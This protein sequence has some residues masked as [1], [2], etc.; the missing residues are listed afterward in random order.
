M[1]ILTW[2][3][4]GSNRRTTVFPLVGWWL[5]AGAVMTGLVLLG[6]TVPAG[7]TLS[8]APDASDET[9]KCLAG[10]VTDEPGAGSRTSRPCGAGLG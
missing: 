5:P 3:I 6:G 2:V 9:A 1:G 8:T 7:H 4:G 10:Q